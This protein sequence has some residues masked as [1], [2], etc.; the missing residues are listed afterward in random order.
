[1]T[2][3]GAKPIIISNPT[4][5]KAEAAAFKYNVP[6]FTDDA[7]KVHNRQAV[8]HQKKLHAGRAVIQMHVTYT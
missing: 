6:H 4:V 2:S 5:S 8:T 7:L 3:P 1:L